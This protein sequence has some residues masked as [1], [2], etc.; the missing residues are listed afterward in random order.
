MYKTRRG[1]SVLVACMAMASLPSCDDLDTDMVSDEVSVRINPGLLLP[2]AE[3]DVS[4]AFLF[5]EVDNAVEAYTEDGKRKLRLHAEHGGLYRKS[6]LGLLGLDGEGR[7]FPMSVVP[8]SAYLGAAAV[9]AAERGE[10]GDLSVPIGF[11]FKVGDLSQQSDTSVVVSGL[12]V[13]KVVCPVSLDLSWSNFAEPVE[14]TVS[15]GGVE[16]VVVASGSGSATVGSDR[17]VLEVDSGVVSGR[18]VVRAPASAASSAGGVVMRLSIG[19]IEELTCA[20]GGLRVRTESY[21]SLTGLESF[22]RVGSEMEWK[23]PRLWLLCTDDTPL[24]LS[25]TPELEGVGGNDA[26]GGVV[27]SAETRSVGA[28]EEARHEYNTGNSN[29]IGLLN[30]VP[31][32]IEFMSWLDIAMPSGVEEVTVVPTDSVSIGYRYLVPLEFRLKSEMDPDTIDLHDVPDLEYVTRGRLFVTTTNSLPL[33]GGFTLVLY[34]KEN[35][36][37]LS[38]VD[39]A[40]VIGMPSVDSSTGLS[41][42]SVRTQKTVEL[43]RSVCQDLGKCD[44]L[45]FRV[46]L[47]TDGEYVAPTLDDAL[48]VNMS[49][50]FDIDYEVKN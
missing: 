43:S 3:A 38:S 11:G 25:Y 39:V 45:I 17:G 20:V 26:A 12:E 41:T 18:M 33:G 22:A 2:L 8:L 29:I 21:F 44:A 31:G 5:D 49:L 32:Q 35:D 13:R 14:L 6:L 42:D 4:V 36:V 16:Q 10:T 24:D 34:D 9:E 50:G 15:F 19:G 30:Q 27:L 37:E 28:R 23:D 46:S 1:A 47:D 48:K 7:T 40:G